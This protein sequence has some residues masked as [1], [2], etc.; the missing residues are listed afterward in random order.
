M[1]IDVLRIVRYGA[2]ALIAVMVFAL[3]AVG[4]GIVETGGPRPLG[5]SQG[6][7]VVAPFKLTDHEGRPVSERDVLGKPAVIFFGFT[8]CPDV[9]P[10]TLVS[11]TAALKEMGPAADAL[12]LYFVT[13]DPERDTAAALKEYLS[14]FD[15]RIRGLTGEA[16]Q[17]AAFA[18]PLGVYYA[19]VKLEGGGYTMDHTATVFLLD[20]EGRFVGTIAYGEDGVAAR[21]KLERLAKGGT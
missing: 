9:C 11:L 17:I 15:P 1:A 10:T 8:F 20:A 16:E 2:F 3:L 13:V 5:V 12:G 6:A 21:A 7:P 14:S 18:K 4:L 19:R